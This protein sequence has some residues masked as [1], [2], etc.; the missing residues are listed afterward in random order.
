LDIPA[1]SHR[2]QF[3]PV[4][5]KHTLSFGFTASALADTMGSSSGN[6]TPSTH[7]LKEWVGGLA[8]RADALAARSG[9]CQWLQRLQ[10]LT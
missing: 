4:N 5:T 9:V 8:R 3:P 6:A 10:P 1:R 2:S 7:F